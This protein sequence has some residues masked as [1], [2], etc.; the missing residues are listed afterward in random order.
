M[1]IDP[2]TLKLAAKAA[3][4]A[5]T[6]ENARRKV[7]IVAITPLAAFILIVSL[8]FYIITMPLQW[9][10]NFFFGND[11]QTVLD[12]RADYLILCVVLSLVYRLDFEHGHPFNFCLFDFCY[13]KMTLTNCLKKP[14]I[15]SY[16]MEK[17]SNTLLNDDYIKDAQSILKFVEKKSIITKNAPPF[18]KQTSINGIDISYSINNGKLDLQ[19]SKKT[20]F[21]SYCSID[22]DIANI[23]ENSIS[24]QIDNVKI[25][26]YTRDVDY[27]DSFKDFMKTVGN[28]DF[29]VTIVSD[30]YLKSRACMFEVGEVV[31][32]H[33][34]H[35]KLLFIILSRELKVLQCK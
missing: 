33:N 25:T 14:Y 4:A 19:A 24:K 31:K 3:T 13:D 11:H 34:F 16:C 23:V 12:V 6:D 10:G 18:L 28:H 27:K 5:L 35:K 30:R 26:R 32:D 9:L 1:A 29:V 17:I 15:C 20:V 7:L 8:F 2:A 21:L 22:N